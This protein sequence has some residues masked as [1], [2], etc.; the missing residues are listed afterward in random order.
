MRSINATATGATGYIPVA[1]AMPSPFNIA[2]A[3]LLTNSGVTGGSATGGAYSVQYT[4]N[5]IS[6]GSPSTWVWFAH[7][8]MSG[9]SG[10]GNLDGNLAFPCAAIR[11]NVTALPT[12]GTAPGLM[13]VVRQSGQSG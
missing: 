6:I 4:H 11:L 13:L 8:Y 5:D 3:V 10:V 2:I 9:A 1:S 7:P 12:G